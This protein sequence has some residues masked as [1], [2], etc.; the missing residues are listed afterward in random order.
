MGTASASTKLANVYTAS[1]RPQSYGLP[2]RVF[3]LLTSLV[4]AGFLG[5]QVLINGIREKVISIAMLDHWFFPGAYQVLVPAGVGFLL[6][7]GVLLGLT[8]ALLIVRGWLQMAPCRNYGLA[9]LLQL[10]PWG[11]FLAA[12]VV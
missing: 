9:L 12:L 1:T 4:S 6:I 10:V 7:S 11:Y 2:S 3:F 5:T 8:L